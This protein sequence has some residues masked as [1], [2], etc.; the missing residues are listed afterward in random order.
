MGYLTECGFMGMG[1]LVLY[2]SSDFLASSAD[3]SRC[4]VVFST[5]WAKWIFEVCPNPQHLKHCLGFGMNFL[6]TNLS[7]ASITY[8][9]SEA[10]LEK[11][12]ATVWVGWF[13]STVG[14][15]RRD[16]GHDRLPVNVYVDVNGVVVAFL[17]IMLEI[18]VRFQMR[19]INI[20]SKFE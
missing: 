3:S 4:L 11:V 6:T 7:C 1:I 8:W 17:N 19:E 20:P 5:G 15:G 10:E 16:D 18:G 12:R 14:E 9:G 13:V 2:L